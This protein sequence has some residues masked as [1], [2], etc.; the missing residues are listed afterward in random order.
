M[1]NRDAEVLRRY[2]AFGK[3]M[4]DNGWQVNILNPKRVPNH[5]ELLQLIQ[6]SFRANLPN[7]HGLAAVADVEV[8]TF[9]S[10][11][12][13]PYLSENPQVWITETWPSL[14]PLKHGVEDS[15]F[16]IRTLTALQSLFVF[17]LSSMS[18]RRTLNF[19][20]SII[21]KPSCLH[22]VVRW[23]TFT[24]KSKLV[25]TGNAASMKASSSSNTPH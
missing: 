15:E 24:L 14:H 11:S 5:H 12:V 4:V 17:C 8:F 18:I 16:T 3:I 23:S 9:E 20:S 25:I 21:S 1:S 19:I 22:V 2:E 10:E 7:E 13:L 6:C